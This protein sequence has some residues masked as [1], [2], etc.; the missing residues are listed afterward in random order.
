MYVLRRARRDDLDACKKLWADRSAWAARRHFR[1]PVSQLTDAECAAAEVLVLTAEDCV[2]A[3]VAVIDQTPGAGWSPER[4]QQEAVGLALMVTSPAQ[5][6]NS[7]SLLLIR[8]A[9][10]FAARTGREHVRAAVSS[11]YL[12]QHLRTRQ[13]WEW[14]G[15]HTR[16]S[17]RTALLQ[18]PAAHDNQIRTLID[19][20]TAQVPGL[21]DSLTA[22][23]LIGAATS[24]HRPPT[25]RSTDRPTNTF[26]PEGLHVRE[27]PQPTEQLLA[28]AD[29]HTAAENTPPTME[30]LGLPCI[31]RSKRLVGAEA[32]KFADRVVHA[33]LV[34]KASTPL[35]AEATGRSV[36]AIRNTLLR[37]GVT[38]RTEGFPRP[39]VTPKPEAQPRKPHESAIQAVRYT[40]LGNSGK[41]ISNRLGVSS[42]T[43]D[44]WLRQ[45]WRWLGGTGPLS[46]TG[47]VRLAVQAELIDAPPDPGVRPADTDPQH[48]TVLHCI[49]RGMTGA[50]IADA[51]AI[52]RYQTQLTQ[53]RRQFGAENAAHLVY[54]ASSLIT[55]TAAD[56]TDAGTRS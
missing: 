53:L 21:S 11:E 7:L 3:A 23:E 39:V 36:N 30:S 10:D 47:L 40:A 33:Y 50:E 22:R 20:R 9:V 4:T 56:Y 31:P 5:K 24:P 55:D 29:Q 46:R 51:T 34:L 28:S 43:V 38:L 27:V 54:L 17:T 14:A 2:I 48:L 6:T 41:W 12:A 19:D 8:W 1:L 52:T 25:P 16:N 37:R 35:I 15:T 45:T 13:G 44:V 18:H 42:S 32:E 49:A 26:D